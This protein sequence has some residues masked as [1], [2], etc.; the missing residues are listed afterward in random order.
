MQ[1]EKG[2]GPINIFDV[3]VD[4]PLYYATY[5][6]SP[7]SAGGL[8]VISLLGQSS[9]VKSDQDVS[10]LKLVDDI[11]KTLDHVSQKVECTVAGQAAEILRYLRT[12]YQGTYSGPE[13]FE[14]AI[15][16][17]GKVRIRHVKNSLPSNPAQPDSPGN[18]STA[19]YLNF[20]EF[21]IGRS[22]AGD[23]LPD[24][25]LGVDWT[26]VLDANTSTY[27]WNCVFDN[28]SYS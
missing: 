9:S 21:S 26:S 8:I 20:L 14:A 16:Y 1:H 24:A 28:V 6:I 22:L 15:P 4:R 12:C 10:D 2:S 27:D 13:T 17:F 11:S 3:P 25:E 7:C 19:P 23:A 18:S 5:W